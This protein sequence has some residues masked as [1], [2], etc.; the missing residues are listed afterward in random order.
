MDLRPLYESAEDAL[1]QMLEWL[2]RMVE[3]NSFTTNVDGVNAV[4]QLTS[5]CFAELGFEPE[6]VKATHP[7]HGSHLFLSRG[8][9]EQP[10]IVLVTHLDTVFPPEEEMTNNFH[11]QPDGSRIYGPGTVDIKGGTTLIWLMLKVMR[12]VLPSL[13]ETTHWLIAANSAEEVIGSDFATRTRER[14]PCGVRAVLVFEGGPRDAAG[15]HLVTA[16]KGRAEFLLTCHGRAAHAGSNHASGINAVVELARILPSIHDLTDV[17]QSLTVNIASMHGGT[18]LNRVPHEAVMDLEMR[19][20]EPSVLAFAEER[21]RS[22]AGRSKADA[23]ISVECQGRTQ[24]WPGCAPTETLFLAWEKAA[25]QL[26]FSVVA[27]PRGGLSDANY[28]CTLGPTIDGLGPVGGNA[29]CSERSED[30]NKLPEFVETDSFVP[31]AVMNVLAI[32]ELLR[33]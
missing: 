10:P 25:G 15:W 11:W 31:K 7:Q 4:G 27:E 30:G 23:E 22:F 24:A 28:L 3:I 9:A 20:F 33:S 13:F 26:G 32:A 29:H 21:L 16:R 19:A 14:C 18:V 17:N 5:E 8:P 6:F 1:L 12:E 2:R